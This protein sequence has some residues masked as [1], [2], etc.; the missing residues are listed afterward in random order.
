[1][2]FTASA[3]ERIQ[4]CP[5]SASLAQINVA[6]EWADT[7]N[8]GHDAVAA[9]VTQ[10]REGMS[11]DA[12]LVNVAAEWQPLC[13]SLAK[14]AVHLR[15]ELAFAFDVV[16]GKARV[17]GENIGRN[18]KLDG[19][20]IA[21]TADLAGV[22]ND[23]AIIVD[24]KTG[25]GAVTH[26]ERNPQLAMLA[27]MAAR[28]WGCDRARVAILTCHEG[29]E[30]RWAWHELEMWDLDAA[31]LELLD[32]Y[33][34]VCRAREV[35][36]GGNVPSVNEGAWCKYCPAVPVCPAKTALIK[37]LANG[38]EMDELE[39]MLPLDAKTAGMAWERR[40]YAMQLLKRIE[41][42]CHAAM[43]QFGHLELPNGKWLKKVEVEGNEKLD[44]ET[45]FEVTHEM[46]GRI[47]AEAAVSYTATKKQLEDAMRS[48]HGRGGAA[49]VRAVLDEVRK[50]G[51][52]TRG[53]TTKLV[54]VEP[55]DRR[56]EGGE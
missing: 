15:P 35:I 56:L 8:A 45:V 55:E 29:E 46:C 37:R 42:A 7:G 44:G 51:G 16:S 25:H 50:R 52:A 11:L 48:A 31:A 26:P 10:Q 20:E 53:T 54:E 18:Y 30:P 12:S 22:I 23:E 21:G 39:L 5:A 9:F 34:R 17:L 6:T 27:V 1:M 38:A 32:E 43:D 28:A 49:K 40:G 47:L 14:Y 24:L 19:F 2:T 3:R 13:E 41:A 36:E 4:H 33:H